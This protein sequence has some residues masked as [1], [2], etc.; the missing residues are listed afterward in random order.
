MQELLCVYNIYI[1]IYIISDVRGWF[2]GD[3]GPSLSSVIAKRCDVNNGECMHFCELMGTFGAKCS[4]ATGYRLMKDGLNCEPEGNAFLHESSSR[5]QEDDSCALSILFLLTMPAEYPCGRTALVDA[6][7]S[8]RRSLYNSS[9][10]ANITSQNS[11]DYSTTSPPSTTA[12]ATEP[13]PARNES[14]QS[15]SRKKLPKWA[16]EEAALST[17]RPFT[18]LE[19]IVGGDVVIPGEIPWQVF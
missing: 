2:G 16:L 12:V 1:I 6:S 18:P 11:S 14:A 15:A 5:G 10:H 3:D 17:Q 19:R 9:L 8:S 4:C 13:P 7:A